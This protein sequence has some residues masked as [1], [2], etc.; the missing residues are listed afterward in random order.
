M[1]IHRLPPVLQDKAVAIAEIRSVAAGRNVYEQGESDERVHY[2]LGGTV[3]LVWHDKVTRRLSATHKVALRPLD[4]PGRKRYTV[5]TADGAT[6]A[7]FKRVQLDRL[8]EQFEADTDQTELEVSEIATARSSDWMIRMLQS[9]LFSVLPATNI[10]KIFARMEQIAFSADDVVVRQGELGEHYYVIEKGYCE[11]SRGIGNARGQIHLADLGPGTAFGEEALISNKPRNA[12]VT[13]LSDGLLMRLE[14]ADFNELIV[15]HVLRE[16]DFDTAR[17][18]IS[19]GAVWLDIRYPEDHA[20]QA[21]PASENIPVNMLRLQSNRLRQDFRYI[22]CGA[23][24]DQ[25]AIAAFLLGERGFMVE[26][27]DSPIA[28]I[29]KQYPTFATRQAPNDRG[30]PVPADVVSFPGAEMTQNELSNN[31]PMDGQM[32]NGP[33]ENT[34]TR[35]AGLYTHEEAKRDMNDTTPV[36]K[37][38]ETATGQALADVIDELSEQHDG[39]AGPAD[40]A[41]AGTEMDRDA[42]TSHVGDGYARDVLSDGI[43]MVMREMEDKLRNQVARAIEARTSDLEAHYRDKLNRMRKLTN[44]EIKQKELALRRTLESEYGEKEQLLRSYYKKLIALA[45]K[46]SKQKA[47]LQNAKKQFE[48]KLKSANQLYREIE[49]M[50]QLL[51][52]QIGYLDQEALGDIPK[53]PI[54]L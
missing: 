50:R 23:D 52:D 28:Q 18:R 40:E 16:I 12:T 41:H 2:L 13:M 19:E 3:E 8:I 49:E 17:T 33:L 26:Y 48:V 38:T 5:R 34:I 10:Q 36:D 30:T 37:Y 53:L 15:E 1:P 29:V 39:L 6:I 46:I 20:D 32:D 35:I 11:V 54:S 31:Q 14:K 47:Q 25:T 27:L 7:V 4:P 24:V 42:R 21:F 43:A 51:A 44:Q 22:V 45:N 9:E